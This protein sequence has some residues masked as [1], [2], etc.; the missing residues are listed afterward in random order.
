MWKMYVTEAARQRLENLGV[1]RQTLRDEAKAFEAQTRNLSD[2][3]GAIWGC[4]LFKREWVLGIQTLEEAIKGNQNN[5]DAVADLQTWLRE[6]LET[7]R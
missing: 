5:P 7:S 2:C 4:C 3:C 1:S 6:W